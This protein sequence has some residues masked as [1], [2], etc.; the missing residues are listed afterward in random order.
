[1]E[2]SQESYTFVTIVSILIVIIANGAMI[3]DLFETYKLHTYFRNF[4]RFE[5]LDAV[6]LSLV[7]RMWKISHGIFGIRSFA[8]ENDSD[9]SKEY[10]GWVNYMISQTKEA[11]ETSEQNIISDISTLEVRLARQ[12]E[13][14]EQ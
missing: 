6:K 12:E 13:Q 7:T 3:V 1:M 14:L 5:C 11:I 8:S 9:Q 10:V 4:P 2:L